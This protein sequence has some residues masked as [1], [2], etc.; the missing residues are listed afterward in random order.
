MEK[1]CTLFINNLDA[2]TED[3][4]STTYIHNEEPNSGYGIL[5]KAKLMLKSENGHLEKMHWKLLE[6]TFVTKRKGLDSDTT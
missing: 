1:T 5:K 4:C 3:I 2:G 6:H